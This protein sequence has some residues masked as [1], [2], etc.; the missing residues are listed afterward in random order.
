MPFNIFNLMS[1]FLRTVQDLVENSTLRVKGVT[2][3]MDNLGRN[4]SITC[5]I[6][7]IQFSMGGGVSLITPL[8]I[9]IKK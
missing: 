8:S 2:N 3:F 9:S 1:L 6:I 5:T 7:Y 4:I